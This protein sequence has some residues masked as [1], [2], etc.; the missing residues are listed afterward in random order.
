MVTERFDSQFVGL[1]NS[2]TGR[3]VRG[4]VK[5]RNAVFK[6]ALYQLFIASF[7]LHCKWIFS[8]SL[9]GLGSCRILWL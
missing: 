4:Y 5:S 2:W 3:F 8:L 6:I 9:S 1:V 7:P